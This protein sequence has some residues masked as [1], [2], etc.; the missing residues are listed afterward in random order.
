MGKYAH[1]KRLFEKKKLVSS[2]VRNYDPDEDMR[3]GGHQGLAQADFIDSLDGRVDDVRETPIVD[4]NRAYWAVVAGIVLPR[5]PELERG[6]SVS[7][8]EVKKRLSRL[9]VA[10]YDVGNPGALTQMERWNLLQRVRRDIHKQA[11]EYCPEVV[12][13]I[14]YQNRI[15]KGIR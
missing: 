9:K 3:N 7:D 12:G 2:I 10:G 15:N 4:E 14:E 6:E 11:N 13:R 8:S 5:F 1:A